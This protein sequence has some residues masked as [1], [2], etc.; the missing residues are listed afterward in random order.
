MALNDVSQGT[1]K[2]RANDKPL[3]PP[4]GSTLGTATSSNLGGLAPASLQQSRLNA[5]RHAEEK[6]RARTL[7]RSQVVAEKLATA[8]AQVSAA[9]DEAS[10]AIHQL[11]QS[12]QVVAGNARET[13]ANSDS[14]QTIVAEV[15]RSATS[16]SARSKSALVKVSSLQQIVQDTATDVARMAQGLRDWSKAS[17]ESTKTIGA[18]EQAS[19]DIGKIVHAVGRIADQTNLLA[20]N[21]AIEAARAGDHGKGFAVVADEVRNLAELSEKS[22]RGIQQIIAEIQAQVKTVVADTDLLVEKANQD[23]TKGE[24]INVGCEQIVVQTAQVH[25]CFENIV[26]NTVEATDAAQEYLVFTEQIAS[27]A[28]ESA[29]AC[30]ESVRAVGEQL[31]AYEE[32]S[33]AALALTDLAEALKNST[34]VQ[35]TAEELAA[36]AEQLSAN[37]DQV[38]ASAAQIASG[39]EQI[40]KA[41]SVQVE[42]APKTK[43]R[44]LQ[45]E[46]AANGASALAKDA[47]DRTTTIKQTL[48]ENRLLLEELIANTIAAS[49]AS[50]VSG[51]HVAALEERT[52]RI[53]KIVD[54]I[55]IVTVQTN[56]LA[57]NGNVE[58][59]HAGE[60]GRGFSVVAG[61]IRA[62][63]NESSAN[64]DRIR[65]LVRQVQAY[66]A[67][68][69]ANFEFV[70]RMAEASAENA[71]VTSAKFDQ[72]TSMADQLETA[73]QAIF[74]TATLAAKGIHTV[75]QIADKISATATRT[76]DS[77]AEAA[78]AS[79]QAAKAAEEIA[80][81]IEDI[82]AQADELQHG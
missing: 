16:D 14:L 39:I 18:L 5:R 48:G 67:R 29:G 54:S 26:T 10:G 44:A 1:T 51:Q 72:C 34:E 35:K 66:V 58:A 40:R 77:A 2:R 12:A 8:T 43:E 68:V 50:V 23:L 25:R 78:S 60:F 41:A 31:K 11:E 28:Q 82:A 30:E 13:A 62:L 59:A 65:D 56:M 55:V 53:E 38:K 79:E 27:A 69:A 64:A 17:T 33:E 46:S 32:M 47:A 80:R 21:A 73:L 61:D 57:V 52:R 81:A 4:K 24:R 3:A 42:S 37:A 75:F 45:M 74:E 49:Q 22:A 36:S 9:I 20:L 6:A 70:G 76:A 15:V 63:S 7:A 19:Q 71:R